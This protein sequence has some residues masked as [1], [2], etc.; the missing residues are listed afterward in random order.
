[1]GDV[2]V[3]A[4]SAFVTALCPHGLVLPLQRK[5]VAG[6]HGCECAA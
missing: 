1:M 6:D 5:G 4:A 3:V 2:R